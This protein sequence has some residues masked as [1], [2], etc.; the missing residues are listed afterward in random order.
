MNAPDHLSATFAALADPT[1]RAILARL[2]S[3]ESSVTELAQP[4]AISLPA[5]SKH[6]KVLE[7]AGLITRGRDA[8]WRPSRL[9]ARPLAAATEWLEQYRQFWEARF[10]QLDTLLEE[11]KNEGHQK[12]NTQRRKTTK[13]R[14]NA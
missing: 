1:R 9:E 12:Q 13:E 4:F 6:L 5:V 2:A 8:Q 11:L 3:G 14:S 7:R 10:Q